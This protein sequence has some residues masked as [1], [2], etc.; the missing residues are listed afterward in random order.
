MITQ[1]TVDRLI[2]FEGHGI[3]VVSV[4]ARADVGP[5]GRRD[6]R[7]RVNELLD[8]IRP[9][10]DD[11]KLDHDARMSLRDD[12]AR[13][14]EVAE[15]EPIKP[16]T[17]A[18]LSCSARGLFEE[19]SLPRPVHD[20]VHID[21]TPWIR[22]LAA[23]LDEYHRTCAVWIDKAW[24]RVWELYMDEMHEIGSFR[25]RTIRKTA[26][27]SPFEEWHVRNKS[28]ELS[29]KHFRR[30]AGHLA[31]L[32]RGRGFDLLVI[33]GHPHEV[34]VFTEFLPRELRERIAG[35]FTID[36][37]SATPADLRKSVD[38]IV[39]NYEQEEQRRLVD[40]VVGAAAAGKPA[41]VGLRPCLW[42][43]SVAAVQTLFV[44]DE[45]VTP[46]V[47]CDRDGWLALEGET[48]PLC[49]ESTRHTPD[50][51]D[52]LVTTVIDESGT[53]KHVKTE[54]PLQ[55]HIAAASLRFPL[56]PAPESQ[57]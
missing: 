57:R 18:F 9:T 22:P 19:V 42:A 51:I 10:A 45:E 30:A 41:V 25:D 1:E 39:H 16:G 38:A 24:A 20:R 53:V 31:D 23:V 21:A 29:K 17:A 27:A 56:P 15:R 49:G 33:G 8:Q 36:P 48:C 40:E 3:P 14:A 28:D 55:E 34:A 43:G 47:V 13:I 2:R 26:Y 46:G 35:T 37:E 7:T 44:H 4:Y 6:F 11:T 50:V 32:F 54:T 5:V 12:V 52:E